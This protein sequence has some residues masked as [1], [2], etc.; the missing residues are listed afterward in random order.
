MKD[1][2]VIQEQRGRFTIDWH[3][4][5]EGDVGGRLGQSTIDGT[6]EAPTDRDDYEHWLASKIAKESG[7]Q[8]DHSG[9]FWD[10]HSE[11]QGV[12]R[13][14]KE[15]LK[16]DRPLPEWA[17]IALTHGWKPPKGWKA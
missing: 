10:S 13:K 14:I 5:E 8:R 17:N 2:L 7:A 9:F 1:R 6:G 3:L 11:A 4:A 12:L 16:Q 15:A